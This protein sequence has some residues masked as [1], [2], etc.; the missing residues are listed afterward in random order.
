[1]RL[2]LDDEEVGDAPEGLGVEDAEDVVVF[3]CLLDC[4]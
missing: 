4:V 2:V 1:M 3:A